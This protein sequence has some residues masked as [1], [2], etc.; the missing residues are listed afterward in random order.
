MIR[1]AQAMRVARSN[2]ARRVEIP[3]PPAQPALGYSQ[4]DDNDLLARIRTVVDAR[5]SYGY[6]RVAALLNRMPRTAKVD[7]KRVYRVMRA[8]GLLLER[9]T[10]KSTRTHEGRIITLASNMRW[11][12][13]SF[14]IRCWDGQ[15]LQVAFALDCC[16]REVMCWVA[17]T[18]AI[19]GEMVHD[20][21]TDSIGARFGAAARRT[22]HRCNG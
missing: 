15:R 2:L 19:T 12:S 7:H 1:I 21:M 3:P 9:H 14:E 6:R 10:G 18:A 20:R 4:R 11:C 8:A 17:T 16:D 5:G 22:P 13:D